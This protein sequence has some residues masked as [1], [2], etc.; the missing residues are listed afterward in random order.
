MGVR[1]RECVIGCVS[2][3]CYGRTRCRARAVSAAAPR[4]SPLVPATGR[5]EGNGGGWALVMRKLY[6]RLA[7]RY[8]RRPHS[9]ALLPVL[10]A[11][12]SCIS[13][14]SEG[15]SPL[16]PASSLPL[17]QLLSPV[18]KD[19]QEDKGDAE[20]VPVRVLHG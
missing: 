2:M 20:H 19:V 1:M 4:T 17:P 11:T 6:A 18:G 5:G 15:S 9:T 8:C 10:L 13:Q 3:V 7:T 12:R 16:R 14:F